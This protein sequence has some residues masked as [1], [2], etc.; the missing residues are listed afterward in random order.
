MVS[1]DSPELAAA[2]PPKDIEQLLSRL[3]KSIAF[4]TDYAPP[5]KFLASVLAPRTVIPEQSYDRTIADSQIPKILEQSEQT[6]SQIERL[7]SEIENLDATLEQLTPWEHLETPVEA[8]GRMQQTTAL[9]G[10]L[11]AQQFE[12]ITEQLSEL[13]AAIDTV[14]A[15]DNSCACIIVALNE[16]LTQVQKLLRSAE[17]EPVNFEPMTGT[18]AELTEEYS[19]QLNK[20]TTQLDHL[21][22]Q[23]ALLAENLLKLQILY[24]HYSNLLQ[25]EQAKDAAP[26]TESTVI[27]EGWVRQKDYPRLEKIVSAFEATSLAQI[28]AAEGE[29][30]PV[31]I[32]NTNA[33][34]PFEVI[35]RLYGMPQHF[36]VDPTA[37]LAPFFALFFALCLTDAGYGLVIVALMIFFIKK[38]QGDKKLMWMLGICSAVTLVTGALTGGWFGDAVQQFVPAL[39]P[40]REKMMWFDPFEDPMMFFGLS[41]ALGYTQIMA[42]LCIAF[43]H[44][45][46][47]KDYIAAVCDQLTW[48]VMLNSIVIFTAAKFDVVPPQA[49]KFFGILA[50]IPA[51]TIFLFS[52]REGPLI[53][54]IGM[55]LYNLFSAIFYLGDVLSYLRLM[56]LGMVTAGIAMAV[57]V[58]SK[59]AVEILSS[60]GIPKFI[61]IVAMILILIVGHAVNLALSALGAFVHTLRL[62]YAEFFPKFLIGG[63]KLF[64]PLSKNYKHIY[65][66]KI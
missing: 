8:I 12:Q 58:I 55:G 10:L 66:K 31:E 4:L 42:G 25:R 29:E 48:L 32:E 50:L 41:L 57:N 61:G 49:G 26:A 35:T 2:Q 34:K 5:Q 52:Q 23:A 51:A 36:E 3:E 33:I 7:N 14:A 53:G 39:K 37:F 54:R 20:A 38:F 22:E 59:V 1:K 45:L 40:L 65:V 9:A 24:D 56:A 15:V 28:E 17:F 27:L 18:V 6:K 60:F 16:N 62:Q 47:Q 46:K 43:V 30:I 63:G 64:Q 19:R 44:N 13:A 11:P 21:H